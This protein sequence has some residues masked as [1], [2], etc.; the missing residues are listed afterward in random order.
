MHSN[1][2]SRFLFSSSK[3]DDRKHDNEQISIQ[4]S[5]V[6]NFIFTLMN[7]PFDEHTHLRH[8]SDPNC[9]APFPKKMMAAPESNQGWEL[10]D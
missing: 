2:F 5:R 1:I 4:S 7:S 10:D 9:C 3:Q 6:R 8:T